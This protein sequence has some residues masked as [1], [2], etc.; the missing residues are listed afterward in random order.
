MG[1]SPWGHKESDMSERLIMHTHSFFQPL[2][3]IHLWMASQL[4]A[5]WS[6]M[7]S[8]GMTR[9]CSSWSLIF[10]QSSLD[11]FSYKGKVQ[12]KKHKTARFLATQAQNWNIIISSGL[13]WPK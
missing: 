4:V 13:C 10:P 11:L 12:E 6:R 9:L 5:D 2:S 8:S 7:V 1:Y 3:F